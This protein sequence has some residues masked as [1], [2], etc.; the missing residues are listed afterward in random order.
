MSIEARLQDIARRLDAIE[1]RL[2]CHENDAQAL[3]LE[4]GALEKKLDAAA[5][6]TRGRAKR[7]AE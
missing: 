6:D 5:S 7:S 4:F 3:K 1:K 2:L